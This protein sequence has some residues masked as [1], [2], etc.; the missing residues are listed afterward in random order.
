MDESQFQ[1][2]PFREEDYDTV[3]RVTS[4]VTPDFP[5]T[6]EELRQWNRTFEGPNLVK[7]DLVAEERSSG[8]GVAFGSLH[9][10]PQ[11]YDAHRFWI[12]VEVDP[13]HRSRGIGRALYERLEGLA[14]ERAAE[15]LWAS[16][17]ADDARSVRFFERA[18]FAER[19]RSWMSRLSVESAHSGSARAQPERPFSGVTFTTLVE[20]GADRRDVQEKIYRLDLDAS[21]DEPRMAAMTDMTFEQYSELSFRGPRH[22]PD[23]FFLAKIGSEYVSMTVLER[24][25]AEPDTLLV[26]F[27]GT[28]P[29]YRGRGLAS[30]LKGRAVEF[31]RAHGYRFIRTFNDSENPRIWAINQKL[32]FQVQTVWVRGEKT[33]D[34]DRT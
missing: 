11:M 30:E 10:V 19:R 18:G 14:H 16:V 32:G 25:P 26:G 6:P 21:R 31:A 9:H 34:R 33:F 8:I 20:E 3:S 4:R 17:R 12:E 27:T 28:L 15:T 7:I 29:G 1:L 13:D 2:R 23:A 22:F 24:L 5:T